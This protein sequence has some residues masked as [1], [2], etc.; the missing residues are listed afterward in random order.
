MLVTALVMGFAGSLHCMGMC[1]PLAM[2]VTNMNQQIVL[3][4]LLYNVGRILTYGL[5][6]V[7]V[8]SL[9]MLVPLS[10]FQN[11]LSLV[12]GVTLLVIGISGISSVK[13]PLVSAGLARLSTFLKIQFG[14]F[15]KTKGYWSTFILGTIN[16]IL[17]C[18]LTFIALTYCITLN[19]PMEGFTFMLLFGAGTLPAMLGLPS[20]LNLLM[21]K[22]NW[23]LSR[24]TTILLIS[25]GCLLV[26]RVFI[27]AYTHA[28]SM[29]DGID[30]VLCR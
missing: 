9:N 30:I 4:K 5:F 19:G 10:N 27:I 28:D 24:I 18:G 21:I 11:L 7:M 12:L 22:L 29:K 13:I 25:S 2:A 6:G 20:F 26:A 8:S 17:P 23:K 14:K 16:G 1:S 3:N 15:Y